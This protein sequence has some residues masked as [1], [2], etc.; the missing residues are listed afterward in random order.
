MNPT[1]G[2]NF[3]T[4]ASA[5]K[6]G[7]SFS[8]PSTNTSATPLFGT[9]TTNPPPYGAQTTPTMGASIFGSAGKATTT[10][11]LQFGA[12]SMTTPNTGL[13]GSTQQSGLFG[14]V[15]QTT[16]NAGGLAQQT[17]QKTSLFSS[18]TTPASQPGAISLFSGTMAP[19]TGMPQTG[20][21]TLFGGVAP[22]TQPSFSFGSQTQV[23]PGVTGFAVPAQTTQASTTV[24]SVSFGS[25]ATSLGSKPLNFGTQE[26][27]AVT[28]PGFSFGTQST[29]APGGTALGTAQT[30]GISFAAT[31]PAT[32]PGTTTTLAKAGGGFTLGGTP[33]AT[34][35]MTNTG[36]TTGTVT[37]MPGTGFKLGSTPGPTITQPGSKPGGAPPTTQATSGFSFGTTPASTQ[38]ASQPVQNFSLG[39]ST[40]GFNFTGQLG[41]QQKASSAPTTTTVASTVSK[42]SILGTGTNLIFGAKVKPTLPGTT[43]SLTTTTSTTKPTFGA[44]VPQ[45]SASTTSTGFQLGGGLQTAKTTASGLKLTTTAAV[46]ASSLTSKPATSGTATT[47]TTSSQK[48]T[49]K[50][51]EDQVNKWNI[52]LEDMER[53]FLEQAAQVN[54]ADRELME[55]GEKIT[56]LNNEVERAKAEQ[57]RLDQELDFL[58]SQQN[59]LEDMLK[60]L[61]ESV[62]QHSSDHTQEPDREREKIYTMAEKCDG[63][64]KGMVQDLREIIDYLNSTNANQQQEDNPVIQIAK[65][66]NVHMDSLQWIDQNSALLQKR[67]DE[68]AR[69]SDMRRKDH[70]RSFRLGFD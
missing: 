48:Y 56:L 23:K 27:G 5:A 16:Q 31:T 40:T 8:T 33:A 47:T 64:L 36:G 38:S 51:L 24:G 35:Q 21:T 49:Y 57:N 6:P 30:T 45:T 29:P 2:F 22:A 9:P 43:P 53:A 62:K 3:G 10:T 59:E 52:E 66:L 54:V 18:T 13:F 20:S 39:Q 1:S 32:G 46:G 17:G 34:S 12:S 37:Q 55:N 44:V 7:F 28:K 69:L 15:A 19:N 14:S 42:P 58:V 61:E 26:T 4:P 41:G 67:V 65:I 70:E 25:A 63:Q 68:I 60:P 11:G 50:Q